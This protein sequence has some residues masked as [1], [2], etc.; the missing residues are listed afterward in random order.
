MADMLVKLYGLP[1]LAPALEA[2]AGQGVLIKRALTPEK[3]LVIGWIR[4]TF[5]DGW[6]SECETS[7]GRHPVSCFVAVKDGRISGFACYNATFP[8]FFGPMGV[9]EAE[10]GKGIGAALLLA[11]LHA[12]YAEGYQYAVI[13]GVGPREFYAK[14]VGAVEIAGSTPGGYRDMLKNRG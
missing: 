4:E 1:P 6:A 10:R 2:Q 11:C 12:L 7:F 8:D 3:H 14:A 13:G 5:G 9:A